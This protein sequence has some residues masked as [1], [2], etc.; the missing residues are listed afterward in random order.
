MEKVRIQSFFENLLKSVEAEPESFLGFSQAESPTLGAFMDDLDPHMP[1]D[2]NGVSFKGLPELRERVIVQAGLDGVCSADDVLITAGA[3]EANYL[4]LR[5]LLGPDDEIIVERPGWPQAEV[6][7]KSNGAVIRTWNRDEAAGW[8][9]SL[10]ALEALI[11]Q[12]TRMLFLTNPNNPTGQLLDA[13]MLRQIVAIAARAGVWVLM[14]E[15]Y[16]GLEWDQPRM[17]AIA[18]LYDRGISTGSVSKAFGMQGLR[19]GWMICRDTALIQ[20]AL[21]LREYSSQISSHIGEAIAEIALR[22]ER[23]DAML[24]RIRA[25][26]FANLQMLSDFIE[27][28]PKLSWNAPQGGLIGLVRLHGGAALTGDALAARALES[29]WRTFLISGSHY[30]APHHIRLGVGGGRASNLQAGLSRFADLLD[31]FD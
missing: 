2:W 29:P 5:Q 1:L 21:V 13:E 10:E 12:R 11:S 22:P 15:V 9:L 28:N 14:D 19:L 30:G 26:S 31:G 20:D 18:G 7:A 27:T 23:R 4:A 16:A 24:A 25:D 6:L 3:A 8:T 17:P